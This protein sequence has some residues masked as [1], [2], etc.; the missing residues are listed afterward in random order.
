MQMFQHRDPTIAPGNFPNL[1][2]DHDNSNE[3]KLWRC[4][5]HWH[6]FE[7]GWVQ[8]N[9]SL[10]YSI[11]KASLTVYYHHHCPHIKIL[12]LS[13]SSPDLIKSN[14]SMPV[15]F[16]TLCQGEQGNQNIFT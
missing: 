10:Y 4:I 9:H 2:I 3:D 12:D 16:S 7:I 1:T 6:Y 5:I 15:G 11:E 14:I 13:F 8:N